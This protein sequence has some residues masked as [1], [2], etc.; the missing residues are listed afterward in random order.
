MKQWAR[1]A[2]ELHDQLAQIADVR[3]PR[4]W[5]VAGGAALD[6]NQRRAYVAS[7][8]E[9]SA[10]TFIGHAEPPPRDVLADA[11]VRAHAARAAVRD[12]DGELPEQPLAVTV[13]R[14]AQ[15]AVAVPSAL[16]AV[17]FAIGDHVLVHRLAERIEDETG[18]IV[19]CDAAPFATITIG[20]EPIATARHGHRRGWSTNGQATGPWLGLGRA[21]GLALVSTCHMIVDGYGH[22]WLAA[23]IADYAA[24]M[25]DSVRAMPALGIP[26]QSNAALRSLPRGAL[27]PPSAVAG[28]IALDITWR[29]IK[30]PAPRA[31]ELAYAL[32][33]VLHA[34]AGARDAAFSPT[35]QIPVA[36]GELGDPMRPRRRVVPA[37]ASLRF[38]HGTP[39]P[40]EGFAART[41]NM[42]V[43]E[44]AGRGLASRLH[45]A[46]R[47][48]PM[49]LAWKR[50]AVGPERPSWLEPI[51]R[52]I[53]G[54]GALS[55]IRLAEPVPPSCAVSSPARLAHEHDELGGCVVTV[56]DDGTRAAITWCGSGRAGE[57]HLLDELLANVARTPRP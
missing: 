10:D 29:P 28:A 26:A 8:A 14:S 24:S 47:A 53:A 43:R 39:E 46:A 44:A 55:R 18:D 49:P 40:F 7:D 20:E 27:P 45:T 31:V 37:I 38:D 1:R 50:H 23:R 11:F 16:E 56:I 33:Q 12:L 52:V 3:D 54:R 36:P 32:G 22:A 19:P 42:L 57:A 25:R 51:A 9:P 30:S 13:K 2:A 15:G 5:L 35:V 17:A 34:L 41:K 4:W 21:Q 6:W 48:L